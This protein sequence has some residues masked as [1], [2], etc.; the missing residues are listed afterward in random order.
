MYT[1]NEEKLYICP[2]ADKCHRAT[3]CTHRIPH[4]RQHADWGAK[5]DVCK[6]AFGKCP[7][8]VEV[9]TNENESD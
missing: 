8:C 2:I 5:L 4:R 1:T 9:V 6:A 3:Q 7:A